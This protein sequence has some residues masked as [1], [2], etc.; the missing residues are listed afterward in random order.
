MLF[1]KGVFPAVVWTVRR[2]CLDCT[3]GPEESS[4]GEVQR[5]R[6]F[7]LCNCWVFAAPCKSKRQLTK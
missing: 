7:C 5:P 1:E 3:A 2:W 6:K 4:T